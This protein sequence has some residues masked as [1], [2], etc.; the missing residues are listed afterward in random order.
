MT[1][2]TC[3][4]ENFRLC[5]WGD[6]RTVKRVQTVSEDP[7][8]RE[9][10]FFAQIFHKTIN[11]ST[12]N[13]ISTNCSKCLDK[14]NVAIFS[15]GCEEVAIEVMA[16]LELRRRGCDAHGAGPSSCWHWRSRCP[17]P[18]DTCSENCHSPTQPQLE[19]EL[20]LIMGRNPPPPPHPTHTGTFKALPGNLGS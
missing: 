19:L 7:H 3:A 15:F 18:P 4:P 11:F 16:Q 1:L 20:D 12:T 14:G 10:K 9:R 6:E 8:R 13:N 5:R 2:Q 17:Q